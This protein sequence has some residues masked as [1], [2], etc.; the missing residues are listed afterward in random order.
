VAAPTRVTV[1]AKP[2]DNGTQT[3]PTIT[4]TAS[5]MSAIQAGDLVVACFLYAASTIAASVIQDGGQTWS[6]GEGFTGT[7]RASGWWWCQFNGTWS[8]DLEIGRGSGTASASLILF[9]YRPSVSGATWEEAMT[10]LSTGVGAPGSPFNYSGV[11]ITTATGDRGVFLQSHNMAGA[12]AFSGTPTP[13]SWTVAVG[14][15]QF[16][17]TAGVTA[18][19][20]IAV[21]E[22][23]RDGDLSATTG[24]Y[25]VQATSGAAHNRIRLA[26]REV[27]PA[28]G[29]AGGVYYRRRRS[30]TTAG[31]GL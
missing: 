18:D 23:L 27:A 4:Y 3:G 29:G 11:A 10:F 31:R 17:N 21:A 19:L 1:L 2:A 22:L 25:T 7:N 8:G 30:T 6:A 15:D 13:G 16:R 12:I 5:D 9:V 20:T 24:T 14:G 28:P 26:W